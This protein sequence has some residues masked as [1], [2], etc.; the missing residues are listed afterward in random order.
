[1]HESSP[2]PVAGDL[3]EHGSLISSDKARRWLGLHAFR[4][5]A[6]S[7]DAPS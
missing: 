2:V 3:P 6:S 5:P 1:M 4:M 7:A